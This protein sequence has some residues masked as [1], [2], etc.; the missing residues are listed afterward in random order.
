[1]VDIT[2]SLQTGI[3]ESAMLANFGNHYVIYESDFEPYYYISR[4][5][6]DILEQKTKGCVKAIRTNRLRDVHGKFEYESDKEMQYYLVPNEAQPGVVGIRKNIS[7]TK[8]MMI[9]SGGLSGCGFAILLLENSVYVIHAGGELNAIQNLSW[10]ERRRIINRDIYLMAV[11]LLN[12][13][14]Y[15]VWYQYNISTNEKIR[16]GLTCEALFSLL[17]HMQFYGIVYVK[18]EN[19]QLICDN[20]KMRL[21]I[22]SYHEQYIYDVTFLKN[23]YGYISTTLRKMAGD[24]I[25]GGIQQQLST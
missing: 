19:S 10:D 1:M 20:E 12:P 22:R 4:N 16:N 14:N 3:M 25:F 6:P 7:D 13:E 24:N 9:A 17:Q 18:G 23:E 11:A 15:A 8:R 21:I 5:Q 2:P